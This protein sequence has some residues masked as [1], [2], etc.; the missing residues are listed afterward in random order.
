[1]RFV[2][3]SVC[4]SQGGEEDM[5]EC[6]VCHLPLCTG[7]GKMDLQLHELFCPKCLEKKDLREMEEELSQVAPILTPEDEEQSGV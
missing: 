6:S 4:R 1:M 5:D 7:C 3:C 2:R